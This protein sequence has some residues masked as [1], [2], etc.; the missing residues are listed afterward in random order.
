[1]KQ[2]QF[3]YKQLY[4]DNS[5]INLSQF[6]ANSAEFNNSVNVA[7]I[8]RLKAHLKKK[9]TVPKIYIYIYVCIEH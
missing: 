5:V 6:D 2:V 7:N 1:M 9:F 8:M 4:E 3:S